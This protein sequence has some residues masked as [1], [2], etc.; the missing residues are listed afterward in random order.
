MI[1]LRITGCSDP[2][3]W[4]S[5]M[6]GKIVPLVREV[7]TEYISREPDGYTNIVKKHD[8]EKIEM[9]TKS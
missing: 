6:I 5:S 8:A 9:E 7:S 1:A 4:Y 2:K 3:F